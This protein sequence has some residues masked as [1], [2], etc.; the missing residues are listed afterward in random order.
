MLQINDV[1]N[2]QLLRA[3]LVKE[4]GNSSSSDKQLSILTSLEF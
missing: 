2:N 3:D 1:D 4:Y